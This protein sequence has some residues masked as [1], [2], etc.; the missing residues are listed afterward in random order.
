LWKCILEFF[1][2]FIG[3]VDSQNSRICWKFLPF[4]NAVAHSI[5]GQ[6]GLV[7][8]IMTESGFSVD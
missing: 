3:I 1:V 6:N 7:C 8:S 2:A 4:I 5:P